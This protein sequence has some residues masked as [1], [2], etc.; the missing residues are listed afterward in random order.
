MYTGAASSELNGA[1]S[2]ELIVFQL[3]EMFNY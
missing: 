3:V 1:D 2:C